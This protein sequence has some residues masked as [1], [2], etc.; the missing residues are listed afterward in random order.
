MKVMRTITMRRSSRRCLTRTMKTMTRAPVC[1]PRGSWEDRRRRWSRMTS[2]EKM[3]RD[4]RTMRMMRTRKDMID[5]RSNR[6]RKS[7]SLMRSRCWI[8]QS[9]AS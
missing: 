6:M 9:H 4:K 8:L 5:S 3:E 2:I 7:S 1:L